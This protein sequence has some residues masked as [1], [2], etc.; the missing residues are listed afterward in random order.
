MLSPLNPSPIRCPKLAPP[1]RPPVPALDAEVDIAPFPFP[2]PCAELGANPGLGP[3]GPSDDLRAFLGI[4]MGVFDPLEPVPPCPCPW[5]WPWPWLWLAL[6][7]V[8]LDM[9]PP[10]D[11]F[12]CPLFFC[13]AAAV[14][15]V[16]GPVRFLYIS[17]V[18][19]CV[20]SRLT[21]S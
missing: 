6:G 1:P 10:S 9:D 3:V 19:T 13:G 4:T 15:F 21:A 16:G 20:T 5:P 11:D 7:E 12:L 17:H 14:S 18:P 2:F 8:G